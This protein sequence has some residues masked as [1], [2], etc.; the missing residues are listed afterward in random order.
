MKCLITKLCKRKDRSF[1]SFSS[2][3]RLSKKKDRQLVK[4][5]LAVDGQLNAHQRER[6]LLAWHER[7]MPPSPLQE[8]LWITV[9]KET[10]YPKNRALIHKVQLQP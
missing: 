7:Q 1:S 3:L 4:P 8:T 5:L 2:F 10:K 6:Q 9:R